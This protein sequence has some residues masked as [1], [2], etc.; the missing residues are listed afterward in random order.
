M[1]GPIGCSRQGS[2]KYVDRKPEESLGQQS[3]KEERMLETYRDDKLHTREV[4]PKTHQKNPP[5]LDL[6]EY[7]RKCNPF[8]TLRKNQQKRSGKKIWPEWACFFLHILLFPFEIFP[9]LICSIIT[10]KFLQRVKRTRGPNARIMK[11]DSQM[12][13]VALSPSRFTP[14]EYWVN[15]DM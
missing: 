4:S 2:R 5:L 9:L 3:Q 12:K 7:A 1:K 8:N 10:I 11:Q 14:R 15:L 6:F 13:A